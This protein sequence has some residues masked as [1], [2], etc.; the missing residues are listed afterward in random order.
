M[1]ASSFALISAGSVQDNMKRLCINLWIKSKSVDNL[2]ETV[3]KPSISVD[4]PVET[5][6]NSFHPVENFVR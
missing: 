3:D 6:D 1:P 5:V 2:G 4:K